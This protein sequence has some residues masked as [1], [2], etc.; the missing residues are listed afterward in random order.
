MEEGEEDQLGRFCENLVLQGVMEER[1]N[2]I[3]N[4]NKEC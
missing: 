4:K 3:N 1:N 2:P